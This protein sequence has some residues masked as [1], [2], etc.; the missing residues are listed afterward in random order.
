MIKHSKSPIFCQLSFDVKCAFS[1]VPFRPCIPINPQ[2]PRDGQGRD[3]YCSSEFLS[4][5]TWSMYCA[6]VFLCLSQYIYTQVLVFP[7]IMYWFPACLPPCVCLSVPQW[8][9]QKRPRGSGDDN[10]RSPVLSA[11]CHRLG[12][13]GSRDPYRISERGKH[14][15][16]PLSK[17]LNLINQSHA[18]RC[19]KR[20]WKSFNCFVSL[21]L[22][23]VA[24]FF[25]NSGVSYFAFS[26]S[27]SYC[28]TLGDAV[29]CQL[30]CWINSSWKP[31]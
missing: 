15:M 29:S 2:T 23:V 5:L 24:S 1:Y 3:E 18:V 25:E 26:S 16:L 11:C 9:H 20:R 12:Y 30:L 7:S 19:K 4:W 14:V 6:C 27:S 17:S 10:L 28:A 13:E 22:Q 8:N 21:F 31:L